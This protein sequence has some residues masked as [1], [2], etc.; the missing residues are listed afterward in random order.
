MVRGLRPQG[1]CGDLLC[2]VVSA[3]SNRGSCRTSRL[4]IGIKV[5][6]PVLAGFTTILPGD[7]SD[8]AEDLADSLT[9]QVLASIDNWLGG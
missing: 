1:N 4:L 7:P 5:E 8:G 3:G 6:A 9:D 2:A